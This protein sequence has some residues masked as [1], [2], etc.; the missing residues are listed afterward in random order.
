VGPIVGGRIVEIN[1]TGLGVGADGNDLI[2]VAP[3]WA[4]AL[5]DAVFVAPHAP[6]R[7]DL[8]PVGRQW[9]PRGDLDPA[10]LGAGVPRA[11]KVLDAFIEEQLAK[12]ALPPTAYALMGFSN[13]TTD[14]LRSSQPLDSQANCIKSS[15]WS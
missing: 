5:P 1:R 10:K 14:A 15:R 8:A 7:F 6:E 2:D 9:F 3:Y 12:Y 11:A 13:K 4:H